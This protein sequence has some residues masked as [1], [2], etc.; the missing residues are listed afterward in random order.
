MYKRQAYL[1]ESRPEDPSIAGLPSTVTSLQVEADA[2][3]PRCTELVE[4][5]GQAG[6]VVVRAEPGP[7]GALGAAYLAG[8]G[9][10]LWTLDDLLRLR[11]AAQTVTRSSD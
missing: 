6:L 9:S 11:A 5:A 10:G 4:Q 8:V 1:L 7:S 2:D 3:D